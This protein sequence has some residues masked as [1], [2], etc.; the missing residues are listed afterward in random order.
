VPWLFGLLLAAALSYLFAIVADLVLASRFR[1]MIVQIAN[2]V[3]R[4]E[5]R[6]RVELI[7]V[8]LLACAGPL[9]RR[10]RALGVLR[11]HF[12]T[13]AS[14]RGHAVTFAFLLPIVV[15]I[16]LLPAMPMPL[17]K[18]ADEFGHLL[19]ADTFAEGRVTNA[20][21][22]LWQHFETLYV[23][24]GPTYASIYPVAQGAVLAAAKVAGL[25]PWFGVCLSVGLMCG[26]ICWML[27]AWLPP[28]WALAGSLVVASR[29]AIDSY[30]MNSY[31]GGAVACAGGA[32]MLGALPRMFQR[33]RVLDT[34]PFA[35]GTLIV[36]Q[37]RPFEGL[38][39]CIPIAVWI[40]IRLFRE[41]REGRVQLVTR[42]MLPLLLACTTIVFA[43]LYYNQRVTGSNLLP[44]QLHQKIYGTPQNLRWGADV[45]GAPRAQVHRDIRD[46][47]EWQRDVFL[48]QIPVTGLW[49][50]LQDKLDDFWRF[51]LGPSLLIPILLFG[52]AK[53]V[54]VLFIL[55]AFV[56][57]V[58][59]VLYPFFFP[60][61]AAPLFG[62]TIAIALY[63]IRR[64]GSWAPLLIAASVSSAVV[65][66][67]AWAVCRA[68]YEDATPRS[69]IEE[70]LNKLGGSH[71]VFV[72][73]G[74]VHDFHQSW[75]YNAAD[76]DGAQIVWARDLG[77]DANKGLLEYYPGRRAWL[78]EVDDPSS[79][80]FAYEDADKPRV[81]SVVNAAGKSP[82]FKSGVAPGSI[83]T[84]SGRNLTAEEKAAPR[85]ECF[86]SGN[87]CVEQGLQQTTV[88][89]DG[90]PAMLLSA[91]RRGGDES[92]TV[93]VPFD[94]QTQAVS[95]N[96]RNASLEKTVRL[97]VLAANP[98]IFGILLRPDNSVVSP[99]NR[100]RKGETIRA[101]VTGL[102]ADPAPNVIVGVNHCGATLKGVERG[103]ALDGF[104]VVAFEIPASAPSGD[105]IPLSMAVVI[106]GKPVYSNNSSIDLE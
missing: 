52:M 33:K 50:R 56:L 19:V 86:F 15:R 43:T 82:Y 95:L 6:W 84:I 36:V 8:S 5:S 92:L 74:V 45:S 49:S 41:S 13:L 32:L 24:Q 20:P 34:L 99:A 21:H 37:S 100:A 1:E 42:V 102:G 98:G 90:K 75:I 105:Q 54:R 60:H 62:A 12:R 64:L 39:L 76:I 87:G 10:A 48:R 4:P 38:L 51:F 89:F 88:T 53:P 58:A 103:P 25:H 29:I 94:V 26:A 80:L 46:N 97:P 73:Y 93:R 59:A 35:T 106:D 96:I 66:G 78:A 2:D 27:Q 83:V 22:P 18:I 71:L 91:A 44:Y 63:G 23:L 65:S 28:S 14:R 47:F 68:A 17:P 101:L 85:Q 67:A 70:Q 55:S 61:Y 11:D 81:S 31:W 16:A 7:L 77:A 9:V 72:R 79:L 104:D 69:R 30:W 57:T 40:A 3:T